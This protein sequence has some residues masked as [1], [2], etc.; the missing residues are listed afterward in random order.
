MKKSS[1]FVPATE[2]DVKQVP[3]LHLKVGQKIGWSFS[4]EL[5]CDR[6][7]KRFIFF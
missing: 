1:D 6:E 4:Q 5:K 2:A 7:Q 3:N